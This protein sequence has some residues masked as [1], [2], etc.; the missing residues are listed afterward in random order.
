MQHSQN[1]LIALFC[2]LLVILSLVSLSQGT[3]S[4]EKIKIVK[5]LFNHIIPINQNWTIEEETILLQVRL[6]RILLV[7][8]IGTSLSVSGAVLQSIFRNPLVS[9]FI[10]G[11][12][13]GASL[14][15]SL[16]IVFFSTYSFYVLQV[17]AFLFSILAVLLVLFVISIFKNSNTTILIISG[18]VI[19]SFFQSIVSLL[20]YF[21][22]T[23]KLQS[24]VFW[25]F[26][27]FTNANWD[28]LLQIMPI[29]I[30]G[31][32]VLILNSWKINVLSLA[33]DESKTLGI[34]SQKLRIYLIL[35]VSLMTSTATALTG[36]ISW[37]G[38][39]I[40]NIARILLGANN[41]Y[42]I[43]GSASLG[44]TFML[45]V[46]LI[47]RTVLNV[48]IPVGIVTSILGV[49]FFIYILYQS[50]KHF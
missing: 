20:Q 22:E 40:P 34:N 43:I 31:T 9:P 35:V 47:S 8:F 26:G 5:I 39:V 41:S 24:I 33:D 49:P 14:G 27:S 46:D 48:E 21:S 44:A 38:L 28:K 18:I 50:K 19:S 42:V 32:T 3:F 7:I 4:I 16:I 15:A 30:I 2:I 11:I 45:L 12:S 29:T 13:S 36:P 1:K 37:V 6:P 25:N 17:S 23:D 10:L